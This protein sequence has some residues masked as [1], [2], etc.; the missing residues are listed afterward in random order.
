MD[1][2]FATTHYEL[3]ATTDGQRLDAFL[4]ASLPE[5][6]R[7]AAGA[8]VRD[9]RVEI[10]GRTKI[11]PSTWLVAGEHI[12]VALPPAARSEVEPQDLPLP[13]LYWDDD[14]VI[15]SKPAGMATHPGPG[16]WKG[17][18]VNALLY[19]Q[20]EWQAIG[21]VA[22]PGI[23]HRLDRDTG[24]LLVFANGNS[25]HQALLEAMRDRQIKRSYLALVHGHLEG[26]GSID[27]PLE[28]DPGRVERV[29]VSEGGKRALTHWRALGSVGARTLVELVLETGR[30]HQIRVHLAAI[31]CPI[32]GDPWYGR[33]SEDVGLRLYAYRLA[34]RHPR[35]EHWLTA[36]T[37]PHWMPL[38]KDLR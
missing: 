33:G 30:N 13:I 1:K 14:L 23:V 2:H 4:A 19:H 36:V 26:T 35:F 3:V 37:L 11:K 12:R 25:A 5:L 38:E 22:T 24:G 16:W 21:G 32:V 28:R 6:D 9:H 18:A 7:I 20:K 10:L 8:L 34:L 31:G 27:L 15:V 29:I 17:S